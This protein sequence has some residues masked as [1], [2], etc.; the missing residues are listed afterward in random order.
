[1]VR[2]TV[3]V[4]L[5]GGLGLSQ[6]DA[7]VSQGTQTILFTDLEASTDLRVRLGD[8]AANEV[9]SEHDQLVRSLIESG[10]GTDVK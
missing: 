1:M 10:G 3:I 4:I 8:A 2:S 5:D 6:S 7:I 9:I